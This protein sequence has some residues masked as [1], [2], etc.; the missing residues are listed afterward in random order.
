MGFDL[1]TGYLFSLKE[2]HRSAFIK[3]ALNIYVMR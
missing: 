3:K 1:N 2:W